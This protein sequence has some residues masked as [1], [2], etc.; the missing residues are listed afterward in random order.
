MD[1]CFLNLVLNL[2]QNLIDLSLLYIGRH[3]QYFQ[4]LFD[5]RKLRSLCL[6]VGCLQHKL[7]QKHRQKYRYAALCPKFHQILLECPKE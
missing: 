2:S 1:K 7:P 3:L 4:D 6:A 5:F